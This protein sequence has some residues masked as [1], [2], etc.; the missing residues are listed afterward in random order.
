MCQQRIWQVTDGKPIETGYAWP[1]HPKLK[2]GAIL[3]PAE[4]ILN[5]IYGLNPTYMIRRNRAEN[6]AEKYGRLYDDTI[7]TLYHMQYGNIVFTDRATM[8]D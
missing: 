6:P 4:A 3:T 5:G 2:E 8:R 7:I 1:V